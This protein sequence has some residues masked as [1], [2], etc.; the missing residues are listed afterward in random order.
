MRFSMPPGRLRIPTGITSPTKKT[1]YFFK[2][3]KQKTFAP[4]A[5]PPV[6]MGQSGI[7]RTDKSFLVPFS[8]KNSFLCVCR[9]FLGP[10]KPSPSWQGAKVSQFAHGAERLR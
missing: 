5:K 8:K 7:A 1:K 10:G 3:K 2:K 6:Q 9:P 4:C